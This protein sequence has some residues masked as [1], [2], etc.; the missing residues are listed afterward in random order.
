MVAFHADD[1]KRIDMFGCF[2]FLHPNVKDAWSRHPDEIRMGNS[3]LS[4]IRE[5]YENPAKRSIS[6]SLPNLLQHG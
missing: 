2:L 6:Q 4:P 3:D 5:A 1:T